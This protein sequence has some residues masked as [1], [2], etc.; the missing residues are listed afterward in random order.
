MFCLN[1]ALDYTNLPIHCQ[2]LIFPFLFEAAG[3]LFSKR[4]QQKMGFAI[5]CYICLP[6]FVFISN[7]HFGAKR[8][9]KCH[10]HMYFFLTRWHPNEPG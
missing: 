3:L 7:L 2:S 5:I 1:L 8:Q 6:D 10:P 9:L 4:W